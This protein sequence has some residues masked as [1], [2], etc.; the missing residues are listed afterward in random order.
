VVPGLIALI[1]KGNAY[2]SD[3]ARLALE[4]ITN[5]RFEL[6]SHGTNKLSA[7]E[8]RF[9][10]EKYE[11]WWE[12]NKNKTRIEWLSVGLGAHDVRGR[13]VIQKLGASG[14]GD[15]VPVLQRLLADSYFRPYAAVAL[16]RLGDRSAVPALIEEFLL[17]DSA[18]LRKA[19][20]CELYALTGKTMAYD[21]NAPEKVRRAAIQRWRE[22]YEKQ[23]K[24]ARKGRRNWRIGGRNA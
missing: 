10:A 5:Y 1:R 7:Q 24:T 21:P 6:P 15:A 19:G 20:I 18:P 14:D 9:A 22:W 16:A 8:R 13:E 3:A 11:N 4:E 2:T 23:G 12:Q 17:S